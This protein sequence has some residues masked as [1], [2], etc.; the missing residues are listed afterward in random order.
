M[1]MY[2]NCIIEVKKGEDASVL[3]D[4]LREHE[5]DLVD[6]KFVNDVTLFLSTDVSDKLLKVKEDENGIFKVCR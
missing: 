2:K 1:V 6:F 3:Q 5:L 4:Y